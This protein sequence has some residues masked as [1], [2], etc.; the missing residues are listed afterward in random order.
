MIHSPLEKKRERNKSKIENMVKVIVLGL[1]G[2]GH[3]ETL[4]SKLEEEKVPFNFLDADKEDELADKL[5]A[6][7]DTKVYPIVILES[8]ME[9][10]Y[11]YRVSSISEAKTV[12]W[13][14]GE[15][16]VGCVTVDNMVAAIK[17]NFK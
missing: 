4:V 2:C 1:S 9:K 13:L 8:G 16:K 12:H 10:T 14:N 15:T 17:Q 3:C 7:L 11:L 6:Q 5:E